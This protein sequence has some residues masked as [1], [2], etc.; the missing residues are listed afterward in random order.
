MSEQNF[1]GGGVA[2]QEPPAE[3]PDTDVT[4]SRRNLVIVGV[5]VAVALL[6]AV[7]FLFL[8]GGGSSTPTGAVPHASLNAGAAGKTTVKKTT[9]KKST[10][11][12]KSAAPKDQT[13]R[14][15][16]KPL[17]K[18]QASPSPSAVTTTA[19]PTASTPA[20][21]P[22]A[23]APVPGNAT[24]VAT[25]NLVSIDSK[26]KTATFNVAGAT[27]DPTKY[28]SIKVGQTFA[29]FFKLFD[30]GAKCAQVQYGDVTDAVC[31][32]TPLVVQAAS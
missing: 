21:S 28:S 12:I 17:L 20:P 16:F 31:M 9:G 14:D 19:A 22:S 25:V 29:T 4:G 8:S 6:V 15:P 32:G 30:L 2:T 11:V 5:A 23:T 26:A 3:S 10:V 18:P 13:G 7:W 1:S 24:V 27:G